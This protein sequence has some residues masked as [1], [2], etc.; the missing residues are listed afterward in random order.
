MIGIR[1]LNQLNVRNNAKSRDKTP[2]KGSTITK[3][4]SK[5]RSLNPNDKKRSEGIKYS[6]SSQKAMPLLPTSLTIV[7]NLMKSYEIERKS[8]SKTL[9][10]FGVN[11]VSKRCNEI[12]QISKS[13]NQ[14]IE[15]NL[16]ESQNYLNVE[17]EIVKSTPKVSKS[18]SNIIPSGES[19][20]P[21]S[22]VPYNHNETQKALKQFDPRVG[23]MLSRLLLNISEGTFH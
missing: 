21:L 6:Q 15:K 23:N 7:Q 20:Q 1:P 14:S 3:L 4:S 16:F 10:K 12:K 9:P 18:P 11:L 5:V 8:L 19:V 2:P 22:V 17:K 13:F